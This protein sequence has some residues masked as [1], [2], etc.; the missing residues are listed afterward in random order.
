MP[1]YS[2][3]LNLTRLES[4]SLGNLLACRLS[5]EIL[6]APIGPCGVAKIPKAGKNLKEHVCIL[7]GIEEG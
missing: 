4:L 1:S 2:N 5:F 7:D 3:F 6:T